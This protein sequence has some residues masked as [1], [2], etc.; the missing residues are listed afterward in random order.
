[1]MKH[2]KI[3]EWQNPFV[4]QLDSKQLQ[5][6]QGFISMDKEIKDAYYHYKK[7]DYQSCLKILNEQFVCV[8]LNLM[9]IGRVRKCEYKE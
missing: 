3:P 6:R 7:H 5:S 4:P 9:I 1:M 8:E 2:E